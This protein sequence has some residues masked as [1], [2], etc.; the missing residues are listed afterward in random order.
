MK[1]IFLI[2]FTLILG[3]GSMC[4]QGN[5]KKS[6]AE[7][8]KEFKEFKM[9]FIAQEVDLQDDQ[10]KQFFV[11]FE[12]MS[13]ERM[14]VFEQTRRLERKVK[15]DPQATDEDYAAVSRAITEAKEKDAAIEKKY[16]AK[17]STFMSSKQLF[18]MKA[19]E[20][21]F[22]QKMNEMRHRRRK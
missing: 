11:L 15:K 19:A 18:K 1:K 12:Q 10:Q 4:A 17:F 14:Q 5:G 16:D 7:M 21:K 9:K 22:R 13:D 6:R 3:L 20:E 8:K 2:A